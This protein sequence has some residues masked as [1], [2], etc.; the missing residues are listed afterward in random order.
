LPELVADS[1][2]GYIALAIALA[3]DPERRALLRAKLLHARTESPLFDAAAITR[4]I[5][6]AFEAMV[7]QRRG[8]RR[9]SFGIAA[10]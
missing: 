9:E 10:T 1:T 3:S 2:E 6:R 5:E 4:H 8:G 7:E